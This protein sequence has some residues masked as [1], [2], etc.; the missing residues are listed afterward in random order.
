MMSK[1]LNKLFFTVVTLGML[2]NTTVYAAQIVDWSS[3][4]LSGS[5]P[6]FSF[7]NSTLGTVNL[8]YSS[9]AE[10][11]GISNRFDGADTLNV[12][13]TGGESLTMSWSNPVSSINVQIWD[14]DAVP[15]TNGESVKFVTSANVS[16]VSLH[17]TDV[18]HS[19]TQTLTNDGTANS[20]SEP[21]N[22]TVLRF[23]KPSG[24]NSITFNWEIDGG[25]TGSFGIGEVTQQNFIP[26][27]SEWGMTV[28]FI[29]L[30]GSSFWVIRRNQKQKPA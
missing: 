14:I 6:N 16:V 20:N 8:S 21:D 1:K 9:D 28:L 12:G 26:T 2:L 22:F 3:V 19:G 30:V 23:S 4:T 11:Y 5:F 13:N 25:Y 24:F 17:S 27:L 15:P 18:W 10:V 29:L 7:S